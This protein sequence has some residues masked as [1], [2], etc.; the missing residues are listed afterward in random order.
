MHCSLDKLSG[1][2]NRRPAATQAR[3]ALTAWSPEAIRAVMMAAFALA[4]GQLADRSVLRIL[5][6]CLT[7]TLLLFVLL[8]ALGWWGI[9]TLL[10]RMPPA[11][12]RF[13]WADDLRGIAALVVV[14]IGGW[15]LWRILALAVLQFYADEVVAAVE[16]RHY[17]AALAGARALSWREE[18]ANGLR[19]AA[20]AAAYN[21][22]ALPVALVLL[23][24][25]IG[26]ALVFLAVNAVLLG[27]ELT[28]MVWLRHRPAPGTD[29]PLRR[30]ERWAL[31]AI[32][33]GLFTVPFANFLAPVLGA[34]MATHLVHREGVILHAP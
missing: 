27:R 31:G 5:A 16:A 21:L 7:V 12:V 18:L 11:P 29:L 26:T 3:S 2:P 34:A 32:V 22:L 33:A 6:K 10:A 13:A 1:A 4:L 17:P 28:E 19:G 20:R 9:D 8:A 23:V 25:G 14:L 24:T 30:G 15:L